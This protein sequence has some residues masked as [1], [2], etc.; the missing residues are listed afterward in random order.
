MSVER[1]S[2]RGVGTSYSYKTFDENLCK[3][4]PGPLEDWGQTSLVPPLP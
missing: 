1:K 4:I 2:Y 3:L